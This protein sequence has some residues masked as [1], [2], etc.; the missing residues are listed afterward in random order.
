MSR[1][2]RKLVAVLMLLWLP[3]S[4]GSALAA[5]VSMQAQSG[6]CHEAAMQEMHHA[7]AGDHQHHHDA[8]A[9]QD[10]NASNDQDSSCN[11]CGVCHLAC[12]GYLAVPAA[13]P[14]GI[15]ASAQPATPYLVVFDSITSVP[16][17]PPPLVR[18]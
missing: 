7:D 9:A 6:A 15:Q 1:L 12:S 4:G 10:Q 2:S 8:P 17:L 3:L 16:L 13:V 5:T 14:P 18:A 11:A